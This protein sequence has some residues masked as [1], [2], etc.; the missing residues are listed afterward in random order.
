MS[1]GYGCLLTF[2]VTVLLQF[3]LLEV[4]MALHLVHRRYRL[5]CLQ[6]SIGLGDGEVG[7]TDG[8]GQTFVNKS[9]HAL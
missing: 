2:G 3:L 9:L 6:E 4:G 5:G 8:F 7:D 1:D